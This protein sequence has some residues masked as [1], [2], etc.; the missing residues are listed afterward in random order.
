MAMDKTIIEPSEI[1]D[2]E[3]PNVDKSRRP[4]RLVYDMSLGTSVCYGRKAIII[5]DTCDDP[6]AFRGP[7]II[8]KPE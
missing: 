1:P 3:Q 5:R 2:Y 6:E 4:A 7:F 8:D